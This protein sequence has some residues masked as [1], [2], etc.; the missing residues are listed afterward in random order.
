MSVQAL[1]LRVAGTIFGLVA[2]AQLLRLMTRTEVLVGGYPIPLWASAP[3]VI[4]AG[5]LSLWLW[6]LSSIRT[7]P[8]S[9]R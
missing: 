9:T 6:K 8:G 3:A 4:F 7:P 5:G 2:V 1:G